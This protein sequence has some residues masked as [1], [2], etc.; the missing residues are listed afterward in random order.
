M[1]YRTLFVVEYPDRESATAPYDRE[2]ANQAPIF[3][4]DADKSWG[5]AHWFAKERNLPVDYVDNCWLLV[6]VNAT[7]AREFL[8]MAD[9]AD[10]IERIDDERWY[11]I[12]E[13]EF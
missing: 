12:N 7:L 9:R 8:S 11:V 1:T 10:L 3:F 13:E 5:S 2:A 4:L 6:P